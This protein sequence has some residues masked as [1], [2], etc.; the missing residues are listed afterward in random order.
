MSAGSPP[1]FFEKVAKATILPTTPALE[2][3]C[4]PVAFKLDRYLARKGDL[5]IWGRDGSVG[6]VGREGRIF[7]Q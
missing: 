6:S 7:R 5:G 4:G 2:V 1:C 3:S